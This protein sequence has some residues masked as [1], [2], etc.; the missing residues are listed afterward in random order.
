MRGTRKDAG[1]MTIVGVGLVLLA[2]VS[3]TTRDAVRDPAA[4]A[5]EITHHFMSP[6]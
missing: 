5:A 6:Y 4:E 3:C 1:F 2:L